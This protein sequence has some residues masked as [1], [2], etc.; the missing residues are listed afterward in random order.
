MKTTIEI[1]GYEITIEETEGTLSV[2]A[3][4][5]GEI[6]EQFELESGED[7]EGDEGDED[8]V[9]FGD[10]EEEEDFDGEG[11]NDEEM[12]EEPAEEGALESFSAYFSKSKKIKKVNESKKPTTK[13]TSKVAPKRARR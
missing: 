13:R 8:V 10:D 9:P 7:I 6:V 4:K 1:H 12:D 5:D 3:T 11:E 2:S